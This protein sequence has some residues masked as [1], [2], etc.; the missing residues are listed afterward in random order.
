MKNSATAD[1]DAA[2][3][4]AVIIAAAGSS[5][6]MG[7]GRKKEYLPLDG[8]TVLSCALKPFLKTLECG[9]VV[10]TVPSGGRAGAEAALRA[11]AELAPLLSKTR[12]I[13]TDGGATRQESVFRALNALRAAYEPQEQGAAV[14]QGAAE[15]N[16]PHRAAALSAQGAADA[17][18]GPPGQNA[19]AGFNAADSQ[20][21]ARAALSPS[22]AF[23][24]RDPRIVMIHDGARPFV[25]AKII[26]D[27]YLAAVR[28]GAAAPAVH[29]VDTQKTVSGDGFILRHLDRGRTVAVQT[30]QAFRFAAL[31]DAHRRAAEEGFSCTD[32]TAIWEKYAG[33]VK[34]VDGD[35]RNKKIT[36]AADYRAPDGAGGVSGGCAVRAETGGGRS[37]DVPRA[38]AEA[39]AEEAAR[40]DECRNSVSGGSPD[41]AAGNEA[42]GC[43]ADGTQENR[44]IRTGIGYDIHPLVENRK[45]LLG[46]VRIPYERG[47][48]GHSDGDALLHAVTDALLGAAALGDIGSFFPPEDNRWKDADSAVLLRAAWE[49]VRGA[50][51]TLE[52]LD[53]VVKLERPKFLP[54]R[55]AVRKSIADALGVPE[56]RI[57]VKAKTGE[58]MGAV[59]EGRAVEAWCVC[60]LSR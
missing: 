39:A 3:C 8:G 60:L 57:F 18:G 5:S 59:G 31:L 35:E 44:M 16:A 26:Q 27:T 10:I 45:L 32:D 46:G 43:R 56:D 21:A 52:N 36:F 37:A 1:S 47:E 58:R 14:I 29:P 33:R 7:G 48:A 23:S 34:I 9:A 50:G 30:P 28:Y 55:P 19:P 11:D 40:R 4:P 38:D 42:A 17:K 25:T 15:R 49:K 54:H 2:P 22:A 6:R 51:W 41:R 53:C 12:L 13:F 20:G 24:E